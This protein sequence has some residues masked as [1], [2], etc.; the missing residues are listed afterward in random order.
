MM[1]SSTRTLLVKQVFEQAADFVYDGSDDSAGLS[2]AG[3]FRFT[4]GALCT[5]VFATA[6]WI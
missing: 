6:T 2:A 3:R 4:G 1:L 5:G